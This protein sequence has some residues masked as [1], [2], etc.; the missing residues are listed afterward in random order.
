M[1]GSEDPR[2]ARVRAFNERKLA[3]EK[4]QRAK[5][6]E[7]TIQRILSAAYPK[8]DNMNLAAKD[9]LWGRIYEYLGLNPDAI[10]NTFYEQKRKEALDF[11]SSVQGALESV[12]E[13]EA[14]DVVSRMLDEKEKELSD[15]IN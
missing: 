13:T 12:P 4:Q 10:S 8:E 11:R 15:R 1:D 9:R 14:G 2:L 5:Y 3:E 7:E 6:R